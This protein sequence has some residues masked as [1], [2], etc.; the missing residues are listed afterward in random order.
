LQRRSNE[1]TNGLRQ[2]LPKATDLAVRNAMDLTAAAAQ[3]NAR[4]H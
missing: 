1:T 2:Y 3:L 4:P